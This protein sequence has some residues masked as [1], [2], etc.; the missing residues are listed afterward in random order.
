MDCV[1]V[2]EINAVVQDSPMKKKSIKK[3]KTIGTES[4]DS[5]HVRLFSS[6]NRFFTPLKKQGF[7]FKQAPSLL[8]SIRSE[9]I[10]FTGS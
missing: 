4:L 8:K 7:V 3:P 1:E 6:E 2:V 10:Y 9:T 5:L